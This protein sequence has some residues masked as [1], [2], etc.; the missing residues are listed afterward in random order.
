MQLVRT[1]PGMVPNQFCEE[2]MSEASKLV[3]P[4]I[5]GNER[6]ILGRCAGYH[7]YPKDW[8]GYL[9]CFEFK[10]TISLILQYEILEKKAT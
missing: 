2:K 6:E 8:T 3:L 9:L 1:C 5:G 7:G 4:C 10:K